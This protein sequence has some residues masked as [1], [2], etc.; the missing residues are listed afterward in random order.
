MKSLHTFEEF[1]NEAQVNEANLNDMINLVKQGYGWATDEWVR[2]CPMNRAGRM[3]LA[4]A[5]AKEEMLYSEDDLTDEHING[6]VNP[7]QDGIK[8]MSTADAKKI[9]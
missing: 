3:A 1:L 8:P 5:L 7:K 2:Q 9:F 4:Q 6:E